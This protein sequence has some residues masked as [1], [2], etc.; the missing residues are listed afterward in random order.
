MIPQWSE[1]RLILT[2]GHV[3]PTDPGVAG[4]STKVMDLAELIATVRR[5]GVTR[6]PGRFRDVEL[7]VPGLEVLNRP[8]LTGLML[9]FISRGG[10]RLVDRRRVE[11]V[12][13]LWLVRRALGFLTDAL[14]VR[15]LIRSVERALDRLAEPSTP[16]PA[17]DDPRHGVPVYLRT[18][19]WF[20]L[21]MGGALAHTLGVVGSLFKRHPGLVCLM[22]DTVPGLPAGVERHALAPPTR[23]WD[24]RELPQ[25]VSSFDFERQALACISGRAVSFFYQRYSI[26]NITGALLARR[27]GVPLVIEYNGPEVW[28]ARHWGR[29]LAREALAE[30][31][32][33]TNLA[34]A[35]L[36]VVVSEAMAPWLEAMGVAPDKILVN[37]NGVD[38]ERFS[39]DLDGSAVRREL[40]WSADQPVIGFIG[41]FGPWHGAEVLVS[42]FLR[43]SARFP[44]A[45]LLLIGDGVTLP[46]VREMVRA[47]G[48]TERVA[49]TGVVPQA[50][51]PRHLAA[52]DILVSPQVPNPDGTTFFGSPTKLF[53]YMAMGRAVVASRLGQMGRVIE[54][55]VTGWLVEAG[56]AESLRK[57]LEVLLADAGR[58]ARLGQTARAEVLRTYTWDRHCERILDRLGERMVRTP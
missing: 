7:R 27:L 38:P 56:E 12:S 28:I 36:V 4:G 21:E 30:R 54:H 48:L 53:E 23:F 24:F 20:G 29:P 19:L 9:R 51:S 15:A 43:L 50:E 44:E 49:F 1:D 40:G 46:R 25:L 57:G 52:C 14:S 16:A 2:A 13:L 31:I 22:A 41:S 55:D 18:D 26:G 37:P 45:R 11:V 35:D 42:A 8:L 6:Y 47:S 39:S 17:R 32:E 34:V 33:R 58:R 10:C 5:E 3:A